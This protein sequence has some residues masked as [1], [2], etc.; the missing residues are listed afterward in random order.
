[1]IRLVLCLSVVLISASAWAHKPSDSYL[2]ID[3][4]GRSIEGRW[5]IALR[6]LEH[7]IGLDGDNDGRITWS[8][9]RAQHDALAAYALTRLA[10]EGDGAGCA[11]RLIDHLVD[12]H[13][14]G[15]YAVLRFAADCPA[16]PRRLAVRYGLLF[17]L[18]PL[19][20]GLLRLDH[21]GA[22][23]TAVFSPDQAHQVFQLGSANVWHEGLTFLRE[24]IWHVWIGI[25]HILFLL[26]LLLPAVLRRDGACWQAVDRFR[27]ALW[28][29]V[30]IVTAFTVAHSI[31][32]SLAALG[33]VALPSR[34]IES[35]I[36][37]S[38]V[39]AAINNLYPVVTKRLA[40]VA[41]GFGLVH[42]LGFATVLLDLGLDERALLLSL[43]GF[44]LGV[45]LGQLAIVIAFL[46]PAFALRQSWFY[47]R[48]LF[49]MG[50]LAIAAVASLW[51]VERSLDLDMPLI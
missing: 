8:E 13:S 33:L 22:V 44:N 50:S 38:V 6:D 18:D 35:V 15:A 14:D 48:L 5:D 46:V 3:I 45:E 37:A 47:K 29:V 28:A 21:D 51:L 12:R 20:R 40:L 9:L 27:P 43:L 4:D 34:L 24:G 17:D 41:F 32:L 39:V 16:P 1:M 19:H 23:R 10:V 25:D 26:S 42:G 2:H 7:A 11:T 30:K 36:A 49:H 31:T